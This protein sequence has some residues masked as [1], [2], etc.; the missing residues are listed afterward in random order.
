MDNTKPR[1]RVA[2]LRRRAIYCFAM[3]YTPCDILLRN[4]IYAAA[5]HVIGCGA[6]NFHVPQAHIA[7]K[8]YRAFGIS[9]FC[10]FRRRRVCKSISR[11]AA[12][13]Q[14]KQ[15]MGNRTVFPCRYLR[16]YHS[17]NGKGIS[18]RN[19]EKLKIKN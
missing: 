16:E 10:I 3:R 15:K 9:R 6:C 2:P 17:R 8:V 7:P 5:R 4:A 18:P 13:A 14:T 19:G 1:R 12:A 11:A